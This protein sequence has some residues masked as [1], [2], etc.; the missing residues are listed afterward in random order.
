M[1]YRLTPATMAIIKIS[2]M[3]A[4]E[5]MDKR[6]PSYS[7]GRHIIRYILWKT[8]WRFLKKLKIEL[9]L[10]FSSATLG[11]KSGENRN[12]KRYV[13]PNAALFTRARIWKQ[14]KCPSAAKWIKTIWCI[15]TMEF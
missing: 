13:H 14:P 10:W 5:D 4:G 9:L 2:T 7:V 12:L 1:R 8:V 15:Y 6:E 11:H 3:N